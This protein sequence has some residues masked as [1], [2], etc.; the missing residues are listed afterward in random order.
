MAE[1]TARI[2]FYF[3][4]I[5]TTDWID[6][7]AIR[8]QVSLF[9]HVNYVVSL[10]RHYRG[11]YRSDVGRGTLFDPKTGEAH[12]LLSTRLIVAGRGR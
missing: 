7:S 10:T 6:H 11:I 1:E 12:E 4:H 8:G 9:N 5:I 2:Q 3:G